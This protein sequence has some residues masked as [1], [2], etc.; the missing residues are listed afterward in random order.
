M[1]VCQAQDPGNMKFI[2]AKWNSFWDWDGGRCTPKHSITQCLKYIPV[3]QK[4]RV[5]N[6]DPNQ[7]ENELEPGSS[8]PRQVLQPQWARSDLLRHQ[9]P[10]VGSQ[11]RAPRGNGWFPP[12]CYQ[13]PKYLRR[14]GLNSTPSAIT[15]GDNAS[16]LELCI[17]QG[18]VKVN[19]V[20]SKFSALPDTA[21]CSGFLGQQEEKAGNKNKK[22]WTQLSIWDGSKSGGLGQCRDKR[23]LLAFP[24]LGVRGVQLREQARTALLVLLLQWHRLALAHLGIPSGQG[25]GNI[26]L[27]YTELETFN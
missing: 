21:I 11:L 5:Q 3:S 9:T 8:P 27:A 2:C 13:V 12:V 14:Q 18:C 16:N 4:I 20:N 26:I 25:L 6:L 1:C 23:Y 7:A 22:V 10:G 19:P 24:C 17:P 15:Q